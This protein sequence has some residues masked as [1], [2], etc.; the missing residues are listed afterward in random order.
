MS[1]Y[2]RDLVKAKAAKCFPSLD[3]DEV[4]SILD[5]YGTEVY[6]RER[7]RVHVAILKLS[8]G[9]RDKLLAN[10]EIAKRD[11]R[12]ILAYAEYPEEMTRDTWKMNNADEVKQIRDRDRQQYEDWLAQ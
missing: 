5:R 11:Y 9:D 4:L 2:P 1:S 12:D 6:E 8:E 10:L 7:E 3:T